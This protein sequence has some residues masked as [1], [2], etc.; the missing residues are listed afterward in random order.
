MGT[1]V[2]R[3]KADGTKSHTGEIVIKKLGKIVHREAKTFDV[4]SAAVA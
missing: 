2:S 3:K 1:I 4:H